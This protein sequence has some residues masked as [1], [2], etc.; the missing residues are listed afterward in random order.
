MELRR[1]VSVRAFRNE[2]FRA[3]G[4]SDGARLDTAREHH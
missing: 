3:S 4:A 2:G 1:L